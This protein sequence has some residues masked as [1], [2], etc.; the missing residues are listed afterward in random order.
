MITFTHI[1]WRECLLAVRLLSLKN[2]MWLN[3]T[4]ILIGELAEGNIFHLPPSP[5]SDALMLTSSF[6]WASSLRLM[7]TVPLSRD[8]QVRMSHLRSLLLSYR[9]L[10]SRSKLK[11]PESFFVLTWICWNIFIIKIQWVHCEFHTTM[12][13]ELGT[14]CNYNWPRVHAWRSE[15]HTKWS[16]VV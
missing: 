16:V 14:A 2:L 1:S 15:M 10:L 6:V 11:R 9:V 7:R 4:K 5:P 12:E 13:E 8:L 3:N